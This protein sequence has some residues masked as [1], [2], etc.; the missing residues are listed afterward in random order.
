MSRPS[1]TAKTELLAL[2]E[3]LDHHELAGFAEDP[4]AQHA[5]HRVLRLGS[6]GTHHGA[7]ACREPA[8]L[9][10]ERLLMTIDVGQ[11]ARQVSERHA[12]R[13]RDVG[14]GHDILGPGL[15]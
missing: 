4:V 11:C 12:P 1:V 2:E 7:F 14:G 3:R 8:R 15:G 13:G 10:D 6:R 5:A 9:D